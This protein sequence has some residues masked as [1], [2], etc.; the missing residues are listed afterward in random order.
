M[1]LKVCTPS[2]TLPR[3]SPDRVLT[4]VV[5]TTVFMCIPPSKRVAGRSAT[6]EDSAFR[7][8]QLRLERGVEETIAALN[9]I[10]QPLDEACCR[11]AVDHLLKRKPGDG[12]AH[13]RSPLGQQGRFAVS[14]R[15]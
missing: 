13:G 4:T 5:L 10:F 12:H 3:T 15:G 14:G 9:Q 6:S 2:A 1:P 8:G 7:S 11:S